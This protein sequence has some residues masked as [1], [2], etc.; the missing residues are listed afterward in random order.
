MHLSLPSHLERG[1]TKIDSLAL[2]EDGSIVEG[3]VEDRTTVAGRAE[4]PVV[5]V[6]ADSE[7][8]NTG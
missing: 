5:G 6:A 1:Q 7:P 8:R 3:L 2:R 4:E